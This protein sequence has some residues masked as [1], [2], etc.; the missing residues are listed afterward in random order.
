MNHTF[1][2]YHHYNLPNDNRYQYCYYNV[3]ALYDCQGA[4][5]VV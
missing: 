4:K 3:N 1:L 5:E 2:M